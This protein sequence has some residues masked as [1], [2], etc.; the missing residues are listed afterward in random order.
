MDSR[1]AADPGKSYT[2]KL[3][4]K[5]PAKIAQKLGEEAV[6][7]LIEGALGRKDELA[8]ES[9]DLL[10]HLIVLWAACGVEPSDVWQ[11]LEERKGVSGFAR[12]AARK[13]Q[14][15]IESGER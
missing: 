14:R 8:A 9:A 10:Y 13:L 15:Q 7:A 11:A 5:G 4:R 3:F 12:K 6:E 1:R 2:A